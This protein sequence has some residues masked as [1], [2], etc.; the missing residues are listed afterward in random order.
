MKIDLDKDTS[1]KKAL[2]I[3]CGPP[4]SGK[5][6]WGKKFAQDNDIERVS[7][8]EIRAQIGS[9]EGDQS[10]SA[11]A[12]SI[13]RQRVS[14]TLGAGKSAMID[15]TSVTRKARRDWINLGRGHGAYI[16]AFAFE[17]P[18]EEL[19]RRDAQRERH[20]GPEI[21]DRFLCKYERPSEGEVDK[22]IVNPK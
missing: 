11:A 3:L 2:I 13:A 19:L 10:V 9:G 17:V 12:F 22:V 20:V 16:I 4:A 18:K 7:T 8:D 6:T 1:N 21:I 14:A 15:A 5:S